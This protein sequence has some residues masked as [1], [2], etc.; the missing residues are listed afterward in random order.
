MNLRVPRVECEQLGR[1]DTGSQHALAELRVARMGGPGVAL[2]L[3][4]L[5][6]RGDHCTRAVCIPEQMR[7][8]AM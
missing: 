6:Q 8:G 7:R 5:M 3:S 2:R 4:A 1:G